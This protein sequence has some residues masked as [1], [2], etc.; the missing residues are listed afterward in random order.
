VNP[1]GFSRKVFLLSLFR[2]WPLGE[3]NSAAEPHG[4]E[5]G[6]WDGTVIS[7]FSPMTEKFLYE[8]RKTTL[9]YRFVG[10]ANGNM[11]SRRNDSLVKMSK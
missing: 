11:P 9:Q 5:A 7:A 3:H 2:A 10:S 6:I 1:R 4:E 8:A